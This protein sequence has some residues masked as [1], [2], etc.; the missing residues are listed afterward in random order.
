MVM[1]PTIARTP[2]EAARRPQSAATLGSFLVSHE[3]ISTGRPW[4]PPL[5]LIALAAAIAPSGTSGLAVGPTLSNT[6]MSFS[7]SPLGSS[8]AS[9]DDEPQAARIIIATAPKP[10]AALAER[11]DGEFIV[12]PL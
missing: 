1:L 7:G 4:I 10:D 11:L 5:V 2:S 3:M 8:E 9:F 12:C 6:A